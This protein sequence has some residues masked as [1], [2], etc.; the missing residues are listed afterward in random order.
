MDCD[1]D[2]VRT[3]VLDR[4]NTASGLFVLP[5]VVVVVVVILLMFFFFFLSI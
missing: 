5:V 2:A 3:H 4:I 1:R